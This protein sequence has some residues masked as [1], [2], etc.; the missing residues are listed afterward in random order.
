MERNSKAF[1]KTLVSSLPHNS[2]AR[3]VSKY[4]VFSGPCYPVF[5]PNTGKYR[6]EKTPYLDTFHAGSSPVPF[7]IILISYISTGKSCIIRSDSNSKMGQ[8][9]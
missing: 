2:T 3:K 7:S 1:N 6:P 4:A 5:S 8:I 9:I